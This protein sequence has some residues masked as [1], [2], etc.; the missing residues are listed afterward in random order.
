MNEKIN[1]YIKIGKYVVLGICAL[2]SV[3]FFIMD[4]ESGEALFITTYILLGAAI[5]AILA[6]LVIGL[7]I[8]P[9]RIKYVVIGIGVI[10][11]LVGTCY[12]LSDS[13]TIGLRQEL[14]RNTSPA[15]IRW[16]ETGIYL[17]YIL[18]AVSILSIIVASIRNSFK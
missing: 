8:Y 5:F 3:L 13:T 17:T 2:V 16:T 12:L 9:K 7:V 1:K 14:V 11:A 6:F 4:D 15:A 10:V 18:A